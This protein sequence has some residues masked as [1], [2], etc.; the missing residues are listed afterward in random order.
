MSRVVNG[1]SPL[2][3]SS[4]RQNRVISR[5]LSPHQVPKITV[6]SAPSGTAASRLTASGSG[7]ASSKAVLHRASKPASISARVTSPTGTDSRAGL[8]AGASG[9]GSPA[10]SGAPEQ[11]PSSRAASAGRALK[12]RMRMAG[13]LSHG[14]AETGLWRPSRASAP[15]AAATVRASA[16]GEEIENPGGRWLGWAAPR[17]PL[18]NGG[19]PGRGAS[20]L[21][22]VGKDGGLALQSQVVN[23]LLTVEGRGVGEV[24]G[25]EA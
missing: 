5:R 8:A 23:V 18:G 9:V 4:A 14:N 2:A 7:S 6:R 16:S 13:S 11:A 15:R 12:E 21:E 3:A 1:I 25:V 19:R 17:Q 22:A 10:G 24:R 20:G